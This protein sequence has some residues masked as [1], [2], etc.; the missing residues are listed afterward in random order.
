MKIVSGITR[1]FYTL[2]LVVIGVVLI[3]VALNLVPKDTLLNTIGHIYITPNLRLVAGFAG[4]LLVAVSLLVF[5]LAL[6][7]IHR[8]KTI[9]FDNPD[10]QVTIALSA[11]E[12]FMKGLNKQ[13]P[14]IKELKPNIVA[15]KKGIVINARISLYSDS[16]IPNIT[17]T[18]QSVV[19]SRVQDMLGIE[20]PIVVKVHIAKI[21]QKEESKKKKKTTANEEEKPHREYRGAEYSSE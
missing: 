4:L 5:Q 7:R 21:L 3:L 17:E 20:D 6:G 12:N 2:I 15:G 10:G 8:E 11:I 14:Q 1:F 13:M 16:N 9:A 19:K 18:I